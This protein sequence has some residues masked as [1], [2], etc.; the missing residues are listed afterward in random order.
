MNERKEPMFNKQKPNLS[1][2]A[3]KSLLQ[4]LN[5]AVHEEIPRAKETAS[6][7]RQAIQAVCLNTGKQFMTRIEGAEVRLSEARRL[8]EEF[9]SILQRV[10]D[11]L[12]IQIDEALMDIDDISTK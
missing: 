2:E 3:E 12:A 1:P 8:T 9:I 5:E 7:T 11:N 4:A 6:E 10:G